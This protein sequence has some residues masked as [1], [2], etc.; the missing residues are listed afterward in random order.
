MAV[1]NKP[2]YPSGNSP[3]A[4]NLVEQARPVIIIDGQTGD[5]VSASGIGGTSASRGTLTWRELK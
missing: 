3:N 5:V 4:P 2:T 1:Q